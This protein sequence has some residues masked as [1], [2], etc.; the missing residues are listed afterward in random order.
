MNNDGKSAEDLVR[1]A[2]ETMEAKSRATFIRLYDSRSAGFGSGG[3]TI[4]PQPADFVVVL[5]GVTFL[6]EVKS[7]VTHHSLANTTLRNV[8]SAEQMLGVKLWTRAGAQSMVAFYSE[9]DSRFEL[10]EGLPIREAYLQPPR[11]RK[12]TAEPLASGVDP[13]VLHT[14]IAYAVADHWRDSDENSW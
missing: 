3:N 5:D 10:W 12:L 4:P 2:L 6:L 8:F 9:S 13:S 1:A 11:K 7:S 14:A